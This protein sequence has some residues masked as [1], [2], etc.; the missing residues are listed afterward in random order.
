LL[1]VLQEGEELIN[2]YGLDDSCLPVER[3]GYWKRQSKIE[4]DIGLFEMQD[5]GNIR[6]WLDKIKE[7]IRENDNGFVK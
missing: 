5:L 4:F 1:M 3:F 6:Y 2:T 7:H